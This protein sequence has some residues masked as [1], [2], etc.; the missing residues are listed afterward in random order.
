[1]G[2][3]KLQLIKRTTKHLMKEHKE[4]FKEDFGE[5][6]KI[7]S[8]YTNVSNKKLRNTVAGYVTKLMKKKKEE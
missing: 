4:D 5:N 6:K 8:K 1:M 3:I 2:R 7:V